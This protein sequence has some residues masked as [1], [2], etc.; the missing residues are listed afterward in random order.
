MKRFL[1]NIA[2]FT[3]YLIVINVI[4]FIAVDEVYY[5]EYSEFDSTFDTYLM[6]DSHGDALGDATEA[7]GIFNFSDPSDSYQDMLRKVRYTISHSEVKK[8]LISVDDHTL[9]TYREEN[10][11]LDRSVIYSTGADY[12]SAFHQFLQRYVQR[13]I[14]LLNGKSRDALL[15]HIKSYL[16]T[17][18]RQN[19]DWKE[20]TQSDRNQMAVDRANLQFDNSRR[21]KALEGYLQEIIALCRENDIVLEGVK[22]PLTSEYL[23]NTKDKGYAA[24]RVLKK[25]GLKVIDLSQIFRNKISYFRDQDHLNEKGAR[26]LSIFL[27]NNSM[28]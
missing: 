8:I 10:N 4:C 15:M 20:K 26:I 7:Y 17:T 16:P 28:E 19:L 12:K 22:F 21:S 5:K 27:S 11:N 25:Q 18:A 13:Y 3:V 14:P 1:R 23:E 6:A 9:T 2:H 24:D